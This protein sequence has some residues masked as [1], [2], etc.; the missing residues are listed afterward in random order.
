VSSIDPNTAVLVA[1]P[2]LSSDATA[3]G[4]NANQAIV[5]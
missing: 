5:E 2:D 1:T 4:T 3:F